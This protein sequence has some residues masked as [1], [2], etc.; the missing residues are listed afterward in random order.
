MRKFGRHVRGGLTNEA[1]NR[2]L[3]CAGARRASGQRSL[4]GFDPVEDGLQ[5]ASAATLAAL[6]LTLAKARSQQQKALI[7]KVLDELGN[8]LTVLRGYISMFNDGTL[9]SVNGHARDLQR[10]CD[11]LQ[12]ISRRLVDTIRHSA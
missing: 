11:R 6:I 10:E 3:V 9:T 7:L 5:L 4:A 8:P 1:S 2:V 12:L